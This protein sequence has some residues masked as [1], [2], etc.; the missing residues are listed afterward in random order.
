MSEITPA[1]TLGARHRKVATYCVLV[2]AAMAG[3]SYAAVPLYRLFCQVT[4]FAGTTQRALEPSHTILD[5]VVTVR[6]DANVAPGLAWRFE[7]VDRTMNVKIGE[8]SLAFYR[9]TNVSDHPV[10]GSASFNV[11]PDTMGAYFN[12]MQCFCFIEQTLQPG[13]SIEMPVSFF[14]DAAMAGDKNTAELRNVTL[15][16][17]FHRIDKPK[18]SAAA[19]KVDGTPGGG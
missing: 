3:M 2:V 14:L 11:Y 13:E 8:N 16:Y 7:P 5:K 12:K 18:Q 17:T 10:T 4:G 1:S 9:A 19:P 15:S 6:F